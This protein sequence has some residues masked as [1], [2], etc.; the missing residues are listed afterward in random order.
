M[1]WSSLPLKN[2]SGGFAEYRRS[3][4]GSAVA[5]IGMLSSMQGMYYRFLRTEADASLAHKAAV[6]ELGPCQGAVNVSLGANLFAEA[7]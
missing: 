2:P 1:F 3:V 4:A 5:Y 7:A 6:S